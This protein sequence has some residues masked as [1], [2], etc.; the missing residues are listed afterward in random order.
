MLHDARINFV[1]G[2]H[3]LAKS[4]VMTDPTTV[5]L[6]PE[7]IPSEWILSGNPE[8]RSKTLVRSHD[9]ASHLVVWDCTAG[10]FRWHYGSDEVLLVISG[11]AFLLKENGEERRFGPG[12]L[13]FF[14]AGTS[15]TWRVAG[16]IRKVAVLR[17]PMWRPLGFGL[18]VWN[19]MLR[20]TGLR[21][22]SALTFALVS[23]LLQS[24]AVSNLK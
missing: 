21:R 15:C 10:R 5:E 12:D 23:F 1:S 7:P 24:P 4:I 19:K 22:Q 11:E 16:Q 6:E 9:W 13:G 20:L 8:A 2:D 3:R 17:E 18:K 14:P